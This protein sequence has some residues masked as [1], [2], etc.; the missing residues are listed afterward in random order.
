MPSVLSLLSDLA[1]SIFCSFPLSF[2]S[3]SC[4]F[5]YFPEHF[6]FYFN[7]GNISLY[8]Q[9]SRSDKRKLSPFEAQLRSRSCLSRGDG[10][11][12][13]SVVTHSLSHAHS[14]CSHLCL[15]LLCCFITAS[16]DVLPSPAA[17]E[18]FL[19]PYYTNLISLEEI[20]NIY[21]QKS[22]ISKL[23]N[24]ETFQIFYGSWKIFG[25]SGKVSSWTKSTLSEKG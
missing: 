18:A 16:A 23:N 5:P 20:T 11:F 7:A 14:L 8:P 3:C 24:T 12:P 4:H 1:Q 2:N 17:Q 22:T 9:P 19:C 10:L 6:F 21:H 25:V 15:L 13:A